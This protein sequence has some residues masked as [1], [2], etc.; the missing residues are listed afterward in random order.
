MTVNKWTRRLPSAKSKADLVHERVREAI[1]DGDLRPGERINMDALARTLG[2]SKIPVREAVK[3]LE[4]EGLVVSRVHSGVTV[5]EVDQAEMRGVFLAREVIDALVGRLAAQN[6]EEGL[7]VELDA[8]QARMSADLHKGDVT[9]LP[10]LNAEFH[11]VLARASGFRVLVELTE[12]L[13]LT[14]RRYRVAAPL[15]MANWH[16]VV[17]EHAR[18]VGA[19]RSED[20]ALVAEAMRAHTEAQSRHEVGARC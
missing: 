1:A 19:L 6:V 14:V 9:R 13:L 17:R 5:A 3:R 16:A 18:I 12:Q 11:S 10:E 15:D 2:V 4:S 20:A 8:V 7:L